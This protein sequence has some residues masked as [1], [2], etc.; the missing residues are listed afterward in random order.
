MIR[1]V[2]D[3]TGRNRLGAAR[4]FLRRQ[5]AILG[6]LV[7]VGVPTVV[8]V[9]L[10]AGD[11][12]SFLGTGVLAGVLG[13]VFG[14]DRIGLVV[15]AATCAFGGLAVLLSDS[16]IASGV[17][18]GLAGVG[19]AASARWGVASGFA[20]VPIAAALVASDATPGAALEVSGWIALGGLWAFAVV[21]LVDHAGL[22]PLPPRAEPVPRVWVYA[23]GL[24]ALAGLANAVVV[25]FDVPY[26][27]WLNLTIFVVALPSYRGTIAKVVDRSVGTIV[28]AVCA[29]VLGL[30]LPAAA[31]PLVA[32]LA[33][34][35]MVDAMAASY[36]RYVVF[37][38]IAMVLLQADSSR[39]LVEA[40]AFRAGLTL[41][42]SLAILLVAIVLRWV[43]LAVRGDPGPERADAVGG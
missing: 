38:T 22:A 34:S 25:A 4:G 26:G 36:R 11:V 16:A 39:S 17:A 29:L 43:W 7:V 14:G 24:G 3:G 5:A 23:L 42:A 19:V 12:A 20:A 32:I 8:A 15:V 2:G 37:L 13:R 28:G 27:P 9:L 1:H 41:V 33:M 31:W 40:D 30:V 6:L 10:G 21:A 35:L 18:F